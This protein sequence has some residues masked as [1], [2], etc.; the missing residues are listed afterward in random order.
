MKNIR[1]IPREGGPHNGEAYMVIP[2]PGELPPQELPDT[3]GRY[4]LYGWDQPDAAQYIWDEGDHNC[5]P[6]PPSP[7]E[8]KPV[9]PWTCPECSVLWFAYRLKQKHVQY[10][11]GNPIPRHVVLA[12]DADAPSASGG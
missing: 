10:S 2:G 5:Q 3:G 6:Y 7:N 12:L 1:A 9:D 4:L 11:G 8:A